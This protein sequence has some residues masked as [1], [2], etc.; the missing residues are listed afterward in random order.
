MVRLNRS[1]L[2]FTSSSSCARCGSVVLMEVPKSP[3]LL[4]FLNEINA[5]MSSFALIGKMR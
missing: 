2:P 5:D 3:E 1:T 4:D